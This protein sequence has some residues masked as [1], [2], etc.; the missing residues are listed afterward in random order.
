MRAVTFALLLAH[1]GV[2]TL[3]LG[4]MAYSLFVA[5]PRLGRLLGGDT[6]RIEDAHREL[7]QGNRWRVLGMIAVLWLTGAALAVVH[8]GHWWPLAVKAVALAGATALFWWVSWRGWPARVFALPEELPALQ[9]R[10]RRIA[11]T[12]FAL[13]GTAFIA[14]VAL[15]Y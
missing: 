3:W 8:P 5:Q 9:R 4:A 14:G 13:V 6:E 10:F 1:V 7:A 11:L 15:R 2:A 12:M